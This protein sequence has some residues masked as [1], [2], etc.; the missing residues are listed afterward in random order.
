MST[1]PLYG[2]LDATIEGVISSLNTKR[3]ENYQT[4]KEYP[5]NYAG[6]VAA[7]LDLNWGQASTGTQPPTWSVSTDDYIVPPSEGALWFDKRQGRLMIYVADGWYQANGGD[8]Y[9]TVRSST[10][11]L[12]PITGQFWL[13]NINKEL[14]VY[15]GATF[16]PVKSSVLLTKSEIEDALNNSTTFADYKTNL[17]ALM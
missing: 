4:P 13:E 11:P 1:Q 17:L 7:V 12:T 6:L 16:Q 2:P 3:I 10:A 5:A 14:Y 8:G 15:D 9:A